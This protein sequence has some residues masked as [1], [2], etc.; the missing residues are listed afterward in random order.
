MVREMTEDK[1]CYMG[2]GPEAGLIGSVQPLRPCKHI[3]FG[4]KLHLYLSTH[5]PQVKASLK[6]VDE[7]KKDG[8][9]CDLVNDIGGYKENPAQY[10]EIAL[11]NTEASQR[12]C[13]Y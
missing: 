13:S 6:M 3:S 2:R 8:K 12:L 4:A 1:L 11:T 9:I 5:Q 7:H 10:R